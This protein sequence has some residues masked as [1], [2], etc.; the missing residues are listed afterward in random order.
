MV[1]KYLVIAEITNLQNP[2]G[3]RTHP[4]RRKRE[5]MKIGPFTV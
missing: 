4:I 5:L 1:Q 3:K 2:M